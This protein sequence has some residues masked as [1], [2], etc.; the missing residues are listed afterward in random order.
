[1]KKTL[2]LMLL[3]VVAMMM[4]ACGPSTETG[5][6]MVKA[7]NDAKEA[8]PLADAYFD[9]HGYDVDADAAID[10]AI[11]YMAIE[12]DDM[13][14]IGKESRFMGYYEK[15]KELAGDNL[16]KMIDDKTT[17]GM[18]EILEDLYKMQKSTAGLED[19]AKDLGVDTDSIR[20]EMGK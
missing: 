16:A 20:A 13:S 12:A 19:M 6:I 5:K 1:M 8:K 17:G 10:M 15:A 18:A 9:A 2:N 4:A 14:C 3:A 7:S 11:A